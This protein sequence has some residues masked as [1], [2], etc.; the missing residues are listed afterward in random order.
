MCTPIEDGTMKILSIIS[1]KGDVFHDTFRYGMRAVVGPVRA[2]VESLESLREE[3][4]PPLV[5]GGPADAVARLR[6]SA[7]LKVRC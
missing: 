4:C 7:K 2:V 5:S 1:Q 6:D 3:P